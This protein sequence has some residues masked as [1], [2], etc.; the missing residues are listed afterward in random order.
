MK[1]I[2]KL[3]QLMSFYCPRNWLNVKIR[4]KA[5]QWLKKC[6]ETEIDLCTSTSCSLN[7]KGL[8]WEQREWP[9]VSEPQQEPFPEAQVKD[10]KIQNSED[11]YNYGHWSKN[12]G[13]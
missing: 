2:L 4:N 5:G 6:G 9:E 7:T 13:I 3:R 10:T 11:L 1:F 12:L 8:K